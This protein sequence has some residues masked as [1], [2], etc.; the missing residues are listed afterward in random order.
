MEVTIRTCFQVAIVAPRF[1]QLL[2]FFIRSA[3]SSQ[4]TDTQ[5]SLAVAILLAPWTLSCRTDRLIGA[6]LSCSFCKVGCFFC[7]SWSKHIF[8]Q[9]FPGT[10]EEHLNMLE[11][12]I[13]AKLLD[14]KWTTYA[15]VSE[16][17]H[18][19]RNHELSSQTLR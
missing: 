5:T 9:N 18:V 14:E 16:K 4:F 10:K 17:L 8:N 19:V 15:K 6:Q 3:L 2:L 1:N 11:G 12:G 7:R 13:I